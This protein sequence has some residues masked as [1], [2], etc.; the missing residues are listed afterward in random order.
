V[1]SYKD[2]PSIFRFKKLLEWA[3]NDNESATGNIQSLQI[4]DA[5]GI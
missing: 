2:I 5:S 3:R 1:S 4:V